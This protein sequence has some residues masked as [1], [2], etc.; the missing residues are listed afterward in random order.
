[1]PSNA[2]DVAVIMS[3]ADAIGGPGL[4]LTFPLGGPFRFVSELGFGGGRNTSSSIVSG[5]GTDGTIAMVNFSGIS[6]NLFADAAGY[7]R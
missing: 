3:S 1:V 6:L 7:Y 2:R 4:L 5:L